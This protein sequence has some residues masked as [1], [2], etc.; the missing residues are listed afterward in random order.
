MQNFPTW[1][2]DYSVRQ[3]NLVLKYW[4]VNDGYRFRLGTYKVLYVDPMSLS[5]ADSIIRLNLEDL[6]SNFFSDIYNPS[7]NELVF[8]ELTYGF[9]W[10]FQEKN[11]KDNRR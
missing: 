3:N 8:F 9:E 6:K 5:S 4:W 11:K 2:D 10:P 7:E 1:C